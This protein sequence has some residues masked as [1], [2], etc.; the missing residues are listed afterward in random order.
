[1]ANRNRIKLTV[2]MKKIIFLILISFLFSCER[3]SEDSTSENLIAKWNWIKSS[4][5]IDGKVETPFSTGKNIVLEFSQN[6]VKT[7]ENGILKS[8]KNYSIQTK[9][10]IM[11]GQKQMVIYEPYQPDQSFLIENNKLF[12][13]DECYDCHQSEYIK[14]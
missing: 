14:Q 13:S 6:K 11:G 7:Y 5:G 10:S 4:G 8:E 12:L 1:M 9:N 3:N 2:I